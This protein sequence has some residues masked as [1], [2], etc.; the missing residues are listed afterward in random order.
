MS[1]LNSE[2]IPRNELMYALQTRK[3]VIFAR[4]TDSCL[5]CCRNNV[6]E[7]GLCLMCYSTLDTPEIQLAVRWMTGVGP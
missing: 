2:G 6:N 4:Q 7:A 5:L 3:I 1:R